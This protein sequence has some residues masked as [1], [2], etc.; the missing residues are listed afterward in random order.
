MGAYPDPKLPA[1]APDGPVTWI[2]REHAAIECLAEMDRKEATIAP[3]APRSLR[4]AWVV[5]V[6]AVSVAAAV[7]FVT[8]QSRGAPT[9][10]LSTALASHESIP[11]VSVLSPGLTPVTST[12]TFTGAIFARFDMPIGVEGDA[13][14]IVGVY[15]EPGDHVRRGQWL[16]KLDDSVLAPQV[17]QLAAALEQASA[18]A[19]LSA[20]EYRRARAVGPAGALSAEDIEKRRATALQDAANVKVVA[21]QLEE[22]RAKLARTRI[23][24]PVDGVVLT[25]NAEIGQIASPGGDA[26]FRI[27]S[28][29]EVEMRGEVAEQ[30]LPSLQV[31]QSAQVYLIGVAQPFE[32][33]VR[34]L[35]PV[36]DP[37]TRLGEIRIALKPDPALRPGAF[38]RGTVIVGHAERPVL[39]QTAVLSDG[40]GAY[41]Y[42]V[43]PHNHVRRRAVH[44]TATLDS[45]FIIDAGLTGEERVVETAGAF[46]RE[47]E[48]VSV[49]PQALQQDK[50]AS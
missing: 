19:A 33:R 42:I 50:A 40:Q 44:I 7:G 37:Q 1:P 25:R 26:L 14:R 38:A 6:G 47:G 17:E 32:G 12:V 23:V 41:V 4:P 2:S 13:G 5:A 3:A 28:G 21:A 18:Q 20:S 49:A 10:P 8:W 34:L 45:G 39:P 24:A 36:I 11:I 22:A 29:G 48:T 43:D 16:A 46:L 27:E 9:A 30:D 35:G 15:V 31:G